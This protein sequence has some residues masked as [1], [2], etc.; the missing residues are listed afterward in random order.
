M[1]DSL[2]MV[3]REVDAGPE[4]RSD[5]L[6]LPGIKYLMLSAI[7]SCIDVAQHL[8]ATQG[9]GPPADNGDAM[10]LLGVHGVL[11]TELAVQMR[12]AVGFRNVLVHEYVE[13]DDDVVRA[14]AADHRDL[15]DFARSVAD[16]TAARP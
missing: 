5:P 9:W 12:R 15:T 2:A 10:R 1:E 13:V 4:R 3:V 7:E 6:W 16:W 11:N 8:C 14:R